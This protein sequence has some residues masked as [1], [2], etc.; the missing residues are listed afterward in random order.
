[1]ARPKLNLAWQVRD[2]FV[3]VMIGILIFGIAYFDFRYIVP[4]FWRHGSSSGLEF[5]L[6]F[7]I[8]GL[9]LILCGFN[10]VFK[11]KNKN[12]EG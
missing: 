4:F 6:V 12:G 5:A 11:R 10:L 2:K 1:M 3:E 9:V 7:V 8:C